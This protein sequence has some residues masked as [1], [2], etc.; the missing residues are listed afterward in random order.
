MNFPIDSDG[1]RILELIR[2][3]R[4]TVIH[5]PTGC[6]KSTRLPTMLLNDARESDQPCRI[7]V[8]IEPVAILHALLK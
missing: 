3:E 5:G 2:R 7:M 1:K 8:R 4:L 6:G